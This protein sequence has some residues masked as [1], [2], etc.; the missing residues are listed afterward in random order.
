MLGALLADVLEL[1]VAFRMGWATQLF[2][3]C[4]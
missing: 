3:V 1:R 2:G 4:M